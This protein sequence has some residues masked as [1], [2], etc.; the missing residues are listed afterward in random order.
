LNQ[1]NIYLVAIENEIVIGY[2]SCHIQKLLHHGGEVGEIQE[3]FV[4]PEK[5]SLG[6]GKILIGKLKEIAINRKILQLEVTSNQKR[7]K[8]HSFYETQEFTATH[9]KF[10]HK[11]S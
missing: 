10:I 5:R 9:K 11:L 4:I 6:V 7:L 2:V 1:K 3:M 8:A